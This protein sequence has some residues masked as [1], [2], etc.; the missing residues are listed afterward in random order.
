[1]LE[2]ETP[3]ADVRDGNSPE[4]SEAPTLLSMITDIPFQELMTTDSPSEDGENAI[5]STIPAI[6]D[7]GLETVALV[8]I[9]LGIIV[10]IGVA[11]AI[12]LTIVKRVSSRR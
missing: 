10:A 3:T 6:T 7:D 2:D 5:N 11:T 9:I 4:H 12:I 8:G 1:M